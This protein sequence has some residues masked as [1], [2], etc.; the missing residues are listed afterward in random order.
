MKTM[1]TSLSVA[2]ITVNSFATNIETNY[3]TVDLNGMKQGMW[4]VSLANGYEVG[5]F[6]NDEKEG[7]WLTYNA[8]GSLMA[9]LTYTS[10]EIRGNYK[11]YYLNG[12]IQEMG[13]WVN[14]KIRVNSL[15]TLKTEVYT[16]TFNSMQMV[17]VQ[18]FNAPTSKTDNWQLK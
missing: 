6:L 1:L 14:K 3:N 5:K 16:N 8:N 12:Q 11:T 18:D 10:G 7:V 9:E 4:K 2:I 17:S 13:Q 15:D